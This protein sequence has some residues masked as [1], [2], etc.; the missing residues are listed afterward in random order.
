VRVAQKY[1]SKRCANAA[2]K[3]RKRSGDRE[4]ALTIVPRSGDTPATSHPDAFSAGSTVVWPTTYDLR[5]PTSGAL[6]G[7][8]YPLEFY[9]DGFPKLPACLDRRPDVQ[10][11]TGALH[12][13]PDHRTAWMLAEGYYDNESINAPFRRQGGSTPTIADLGR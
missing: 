7:D 5:G 8:D 4:S 9:E 1:C 13:E 10:Q 11:I 3:H 12:V 6:Q 2:T